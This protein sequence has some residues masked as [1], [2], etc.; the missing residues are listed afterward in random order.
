ME[1]HKQWGHGPWEAE[2]NEVVWNDEVTG[3]PCLI[4]RDTFGYLS[5]FVGVQENSRY[6]GMGAGE[7][8]FSTHGG[9]AAAGRKSSDPLRRG[10]WWFG[11]DCAHHLDVVPGLP[12]QSGEYRDIDYV[13]TE[14]SKLATQIAAPPVE[15]V[16]GGGVG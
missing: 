12:G 4:V 7:V 16:A 11:F 15:A 1:N 3:L 13:R 5:G 6:H 9:V 14:C 8:F 10:L 2:P